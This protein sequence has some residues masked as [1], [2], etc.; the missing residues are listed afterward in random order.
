VPL[1]TQGVQAWDRYAYV[2]NSP[3]RHKDPSGHFS[4]AEI[5]FM[6]EVK[7]WDEVLTWRICYAIM[8][9]ISW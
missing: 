4:E 9:T 6:L 3:V 1:A 2:N 8:V 7:S 5:T